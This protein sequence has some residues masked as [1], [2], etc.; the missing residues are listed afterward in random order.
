MRSS[1]WLLFLGWSGVVAW[2]ASITGKIWDPSGAVVPGA[3]IRVVNVE[4]GLQRLTFS[5]E[6]GS[7]AVTSLPPGTYEI[8][9]QHEGFVTVRR[10]GVRVP[11]GHEVR[12]D[13]T[14]AIVEI[15]ETI[16]VTGPLL[17]T[18]ASNELVTVIPR[19]ALASLPLNGRNFTRL[20]T[21]AAGA[22]PVSTAQGS[23]VGTGDSAPT[24]IPGTDFARPSI[25]GQQNRSQV[26]YIDGILNTD[27]RGNCYAVLP[28]IDS[29]EEFQLLAH[30]DKAEW[31]GVTGG[32]VNLATKS[33][34]NE[35]A[36]TAFWLVRN[37]ALDARD[38]FKDA[39]RPH[40]APFR[41]NQFGLTIGGPAVPH[42]LLYS[43]G[44]DG[45]RYRKPSQL[46]SRVPTP[47]EL[48]GDFSASI[49][50]RLIFDPATT[51]RDP[52]GNYVRDP[53]PANRI[54]V[55]RL[56]QPVQKFLQIY[57][58][59]PNTA[60]PVFNFINEVSSRDDADSFQLRWD[61]QHPRGSSLMARWNRQLRRSI[62]PGGL[63]RST[64]TRMTADHW[65]LSWTLTVSAN[66]VISLR[67]GVG[68]RDFVEYLE[69]HRAGL[70]PMQQLGFQNVELFG[71]LQVRLENPWEG[72][73]GV[74]GPAIR[75]NPTYNAAA[76][77]SWVRGSHTWKAGFQWVTVERLQ[78]NR[79][80]RF[81]FSDSVTAHPLQAGTTGISLA[82]ALLGLPSSYE[83]YLPEEG[84]VDFS[85]GT[86]ALFVQDSVRLSRSL[87]LNFG[88]RFDH[89]GRA[90]LHRGFQAGPDLDR[91]VWWV[92]L[93]AMPPPCS[94]LRRPPCLPVARF[95]DIPHADR[96]VLSK[97]MNPIPMPV[98]DN[99]GPRVGF[100]YR[101]GTN[102][103]LRAGYGLYWD[104]LVSNS[105]SIQH[106]LE[107]RWPATVGFSGVANRL[108]E[109]LV[110]IIELQRQWTVPM[111][112]PSPWE[113]QGWANDPDRKDPY[114]HQWHL[115]IQHQPTPELRLAV[116]Y[117]GSVNGRLDYT[118][119]G[120]S[121]LWPGPGT[122][123]EVRQRRPVPYLSA[124]MFYSRSIGRG[125]Y[126][127]LIIKVHRRWTRTLEFQAAYTWS[128]SIDTGSS[129]WFGAENGP[130]GSSATQ[131]YH[132][133]KANRSVS[134]YNVPHFL[135]AY[136]IWQLP[137]SSGR[138]TNCKHFCAWLL[139]DWQ[140]NF[141][142]QWRSGQPYN[143]SVPGDVANIGA[144]RPGWNYARPHLIGNPRVAE[145]TV[146][147]FFNPEAF[148][149]PRFEYG[150]FGRNVLS[151]DRVFN[152]DLALVRQ[153]ALSRERRKLELRL[154][155]FNATNHIDWAPPGTVIGT[156]AAGRITAVAHSPRVLQ[157]GMRLTY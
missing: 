82:S 67:G 41:Q 118:G 148:A 59:E 29:V 84:R 4:T 117:V 30:S 63:K 132:D 80:Q 18:D 143:L 77:V 157:L 68:R 137:I 152:L 141:I 20:L 14:L 1:G 11:V 116:G 147:R 127:G 129:G 139:Q 135:S 51:R 78:V 65:G 131:N 26:Y 113:F 21:L 94:L 44:Y 110:P 103:V 146:E 25:Y 72:D 134:A 55:S 119:L 138:S 142:V 54:P 43:V 145:P 99:W 46:F 74:R 61:Y 91:G 42:R 149:V 17:E 153:I 96:I 48:A 121:A 114:S 156:P 24:G 34:T 64:E 32:I 22:T 6:V 71:G 39:L 93:P 108:G 58:E 92:G 3:E 90:H 5:N 112:E 15:A 97:P 106:N 62:L 125:N 79:Y 69:Q 38:P 13:F 50:P 126:N 36:G 70:E 35:L 53:F 7:Y 154:E 124:R 102:T 16:E 52:V 37:N 87:N 136:W 49:L 128:K 40:P 123:E 75:E 144:D 98:W 60:H 33:G 105:Q 95:E 86:W 115:E 66:T 19:R 31:G 107:G 2:G 45:W 140:V 9:V 150:N 83:G 101:V 109:P 73:I 81:Q 76:D 155:A 27:F 89:T 57:A 122:P 151:S 56:S 47:A 120:N 12:V 88:L 10:S 104:A 8:I 28:N 133:P 100:A 130:G 85:V 23:Q 111:P